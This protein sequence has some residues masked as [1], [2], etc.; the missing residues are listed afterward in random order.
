MLLDVRL[1]ID[2]SSTEQEVLIQKQDY[3]IA[4]QSSYTHLSFILDLNAIMIGTVLFKKEKR[5]CKQKLYFG[6][7]HFPLFFR[8]L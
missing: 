8:R 1:L 6:N 4:P 3:K 5:V 2:S 7:V